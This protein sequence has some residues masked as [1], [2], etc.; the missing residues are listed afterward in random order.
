MSLNS[1]EYFVIDVQ[2]ER[3]RTVVSAVAKESEQ[4]FAQSTEQ[5]SVGVGR[6]NQATVSRTQIKPNRIRNVTTTNTQT[7]STQVSTGG[8]QTFAQDKEAGA[9]S[10]DRETKSIQNMVLVFHGYIQVV[11]KV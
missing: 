1:G 10:F 6:Q 7:R 3:T 8:Q 4:S 9:V 5:Q 2:Q 11:K